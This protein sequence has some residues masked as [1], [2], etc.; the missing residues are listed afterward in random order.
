[1]T[2]STKRTAISKKASVVNIT[3][4]PFSASRSTVLHGWQ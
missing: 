4:T 3:A 1:M 2:L